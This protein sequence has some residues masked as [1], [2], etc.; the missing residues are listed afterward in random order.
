M[1]DEGAELG[2]VAL[3]VRRPVKGKCQEHD[4][5]AGKQHEACG[6][7]HDGGIDITMTRSASGQVVCKNTAIAK[8]GELIPNFDL[9]K[10]ARARG[11]PLA[12]L[13]LPRGLSPTQLAGGFKSE[14]WLTRNGR[15]VNAKSIMGVMMLAAE[16]GATILVNEKNRGFGPAAKIALP[17]PMRSTERIS[18]A[19]AAG[20]TWHRPQAC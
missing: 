3:P 2:L 6:H 17:V 4:I 20:A 18:I 15:R 13:E 1:V 7:L 14:I 11:N 16:E 5:G 8:V 9:G 19:G 10:G 12:L